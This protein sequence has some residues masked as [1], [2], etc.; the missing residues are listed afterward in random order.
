[1]LQELPVVE[2]RYLI[3]ERCRT[4]AGGH[5]RNDALAPVFAPSPARA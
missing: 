2:Q 5:E 1:M 4:A 3:G